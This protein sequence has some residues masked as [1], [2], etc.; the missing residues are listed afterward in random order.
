MNKTGIRNMSARCKKKSALP[1]PWDVPPT[2]PQNGMLPPAPQLDAFHPLPATPTMGCPSPTPH[3]GMLPPPHPAGAR[4]RGGCA[5]GGR[6]NRVSRQRARASRDAFRLLGN[7]STTCRLAAP[8]HVRQPRER[9]RSRGVNLR[10][11]RD[12]T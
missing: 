5:R 3:N 2:P 11:S 8:G 1:P 6:Y 7:A 12:P 10:R 4:G 9:G